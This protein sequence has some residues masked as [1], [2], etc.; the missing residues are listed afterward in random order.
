MKKVELTLWFL[1]FIAITVWNYGYPAA[2]PFLDVFVSV[3]L[4]LFNVLIIKILNKK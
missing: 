2:T 1:W 4:A 3:M